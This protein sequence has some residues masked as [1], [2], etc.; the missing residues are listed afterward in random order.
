MYTHAINFFLIPT[1]NFMNSSVMSLQ[2]TANVPLNLL[3]NQGISTFCKDKLG[4]TYSG[5]KQ[6]ASIK[7][8]Y[9]KFTKQGEILKCFEWMLRN[10]FCCFCFG[11]FFGHTQT[12]AWSYIVTFKP[13]ISIQALT[14]RL[15]NLR[16]CYILGHWPS[17]PYLVKSALQQHPN[18]MQAF[19]RRYVLAWNHNLS[20]SSSSEQISSDHLA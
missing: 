9:S 2:A 8:T 3:S 1:I 15:E 18:K 12:A 4:S 6:W 11:F 16:S 5:Q 10:F 17:A 7:V 14:L 19:F 20:N 13:F